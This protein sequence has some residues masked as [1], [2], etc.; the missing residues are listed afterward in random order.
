MANKRNRATVR[1]SEGDERARQAAHM[2]AAMR[3][4]GAAGAARG[5]ERGYVTG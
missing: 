3:R 4:E 2:I 1:P 5:R